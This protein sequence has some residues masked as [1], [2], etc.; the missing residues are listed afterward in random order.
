MADQRAEERIEK[1][2]S[3]Q[4]AAQAGIVLLRDVPCYAA[5]DHMSKPHSVGQIH[6][7]HDCITCGG[8][9]GC[10]RCGSVVSTPQHS[11][12]NTVCRGWCPTGAQRPF[13]WLFQGKRPWGDPWPNGEEEPVP[14][15][16]KS[17]NIEHMCA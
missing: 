1:S 16:I 5:S 11:A 7:S 12:I 6:D 13:R 10:N 15:R 2:A 17:G 14:R 3:A 4:I 9:V 8:F